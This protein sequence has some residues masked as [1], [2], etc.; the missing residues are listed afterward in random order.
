MT[1]RRKAHHYSHT[2][3]QMFL[4]LRGHLNIG[5]KFLTQKNRVSGESLM[6]RALCGNSIRHVVA[7]T[8]W[9]F[10]FA[11]PV[12]QTASLIPLF[13]VPRREHGQRCKI[14]FGSVPN[15]V[16]RRT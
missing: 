14:F 11:I 9:H 4:L 3:P 8:A 5:Y 13:A 6:F 10:V 2:A 12:P 16:G 7:E 15:R 1:P